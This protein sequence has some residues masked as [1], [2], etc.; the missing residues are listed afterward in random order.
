M[1]PISREDFAEFVRNMR[2]SLGMTQYGF[3][4]QAGIAAETVRKWEKEA[5]FPKNV[6]ETL[7]MIRT[8]VKAEM[9]K[10]REE[11]W[12]TLQST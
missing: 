9:H 12:K 10:R 7:K 2:E 8:F 6:D 3:A 11:G 1:E 5:S 4:K